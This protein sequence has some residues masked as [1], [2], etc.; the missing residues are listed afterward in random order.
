MTK[1]PKKDTMKRYLLTLIILIA[2]SPMWAQMFPL[3]NA[4][5]VAKADPWIL[6]TN[7]WNDAALTS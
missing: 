1:K 7:L 5:D 3:Y 2:A 4:D 6:L